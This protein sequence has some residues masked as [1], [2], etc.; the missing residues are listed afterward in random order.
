[1]GV[2]VVDR[3]RIEADWTCPRRRYW[4][5]EFEGTGVVPTQQA[6]ALR[7]GILIHQGLE[8]L[9][10]TDDW[11]AAVGHMLQQEEWQA[12]SQEE[13]WLAEALVM[14]FALTV[15]PRWR[16]TYERI[17]V[18][19]ELEM[20]HDGVLY[21]VRPDV[22]LRDKQTGDIWYPDFKTFSGGWQN[23]KWMH[24]LQQHLTVLACEKAVG[25]T[26][27]G[28]W[29]QGLNKGYR[30]NQKLYHTLVYGYR[31]HG[32]PGLYD[33]QYL[34]KRKPGFERFPAAE[35][36]NTVSG[37][38]GIAAWIHHL[39]QVDPQIVR[40]CF[41]ATQPIFLNRAMMTSFLEQRT[42][43]EK[44]I[45]AATDLT[46]FPQ[47]FSA[48][49]PYYGTCPYLECCWEPNTGKDPIGSGLYVERHPH[50][51]AELQLK[52]AHNA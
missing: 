16:R 6:P 2:I 46:P 22:L 41:P 3:T 14:G 50:H 10:S 7:F 11:A 44:E 40:D 12:A 23:R 47:N 31:K 36:E 26:I 30:R 29:V 52:E 18:E 25:Q 49:E 20:E 34:A 15:W 51:A 37:G 43:R 45:A 13:Q 9:T 38:R 39:L 33:T 19:Q 27:T 8:V 4:L 1:M 35:Y 5:T 48:C 42:R 17:A 24:A 32:A 28:A 21:M